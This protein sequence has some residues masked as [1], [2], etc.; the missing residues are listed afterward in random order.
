MIIRL[1]QEHLAKSKEAYVPHFIWA[2]L[3]GL[4][5][6]WAGIASIIHGCVPGFFQGTAAKTVIDLYHKRLVGH[7]NKEYQ[8][9]IDSKK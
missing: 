8:D 4:R 1:C 5:L 9:Y 6:I 2:L 7:P 3:A